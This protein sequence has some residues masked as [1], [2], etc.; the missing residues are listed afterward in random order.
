MDPTPL[1]GPGGRTRL[2]GR[3]GRRLAVAALALLVGFGSAGTVRADSC[4]RYGRDYGRDY[5]RGYGRQDRYRDRHDARYGDD[6]RHRR[7]SYAYR[8]YYYDCSCERWRQ[9]G[10]YDT[11]CEAERTVRHL[12]HERHVQAYYRAEP[13]A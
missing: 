13:C 9:Y 5:D 1:A 3:T 6:Y 11:E 2:H 8:V 4:D 12:R 10:S 7:H